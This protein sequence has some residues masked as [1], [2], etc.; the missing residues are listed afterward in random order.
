VCRKQPSDRAERA[1]YGLRFDGEYNAVGPV[2]ERRGIRSDVDAKTLLQTRPAFRTRVAA[3]N[4]ILAELGVGEQP[5]DQG[6]R[7]VAPADDADVARFHDP[8]STAFAGGCWMPCSG[9]E[10]LQT[11]EHPSV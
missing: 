7:H 4:T 11:V 2:D 5:R 8:F 3:A 6:C 10:V 9:K 1:L